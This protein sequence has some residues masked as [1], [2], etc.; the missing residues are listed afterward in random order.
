MKV[1]IADDHPLMLGAVRR[2]LEAAEGFEVV[3]ETR[4]GP[5]VLPLIGRT[6]PDVVL[7]DLRMP[8]LDGL[9]CLD[10]I[11]ARHPE[12]K[13][14][15]LSVSSEP[16]VIHAAFDHGACGYLVKS[17][18]LAEVASALKQ[19]L[20]GTAYEAVGLPATNEESAA[21]AAGL[22]ERE[23][24]ILTGLT[25]GLTNQALARELWVTEQTIKFHLT[26]V[27]RKLKVANRT[28]AARWAF[29][30]GM[31]SEADLVEERIA[32]VA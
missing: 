15:V 12:T 23:Q 22:T 3:A 1:L 8:D 29:T 4:K 7:L 28:E 17:I 9:A 24:T 10:R 6:K 18:E 21:T 26:N 32:S 25:R 14:V 2:V 27:Y 13:V 19:A 30:H 16:D 31:L 20:D 11:A 5:E